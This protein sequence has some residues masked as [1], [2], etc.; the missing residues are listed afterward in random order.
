MTELL[1]G[2]LVRQATSVGDGTSSLW[3]WAEL[4]PGQDEIVLP[5]GLARMAEGSRMRITVRG[6]TQAPPWLAE[7]VGTVPVVDPRSERLVGHA[8]RWWAPGYVAAWLD[9]ADRLA[10][11]LDGDDRVA[12]VT[13]GCPLAG[14]GDA[15][16]RFGG[17]ALNRASYVLAGW[18]D[19]ADWDATVAMVEG[20]AERWKAT[21]QTLWVAP[22][23]EMS[24][25]SVRRHMEPV[26]A[27]AE[28]LARSVGHRLLLGA[29][30]RLAPD[31]S[32]APLL[33]RLADATGP[34]AAV[35]AAGDEPGWQAVYGAAGIVLTSVEHSHR[36]MSESS[37][38][39]AW[40]Q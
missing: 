18:N 29:A 8:A 11:Q 19:E 25:G 6:G 15:F 34:R 26:L 4:Q 30:R 5:V 21:T 37:R 10:E 16:D 14:T 7:Q 31:E 24:L 3:S 12:E 22:R 33:A 17:L 9:L 2:T 13:L 35:S 23:E 27:L 28:S 38:G 39:T 40:E 32:F 1:T 20:Q 36:L